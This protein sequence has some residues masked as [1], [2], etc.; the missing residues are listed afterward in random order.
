MSNDASVVTNGIAEVRRDHVWQW[1][2]G[3]HGTSGF[4][5][6]QGGS[7]TLLDTC[8]A[9]LILEGIGRLGDATHEQRESMGQFILA[10]QDRATGLFVDRDAVATSGIG[11]WQA[12][13]RGSWFALQALDALGMHP[14]H[15]FHF[16]D[17]IADR[18]GMIG[19]LKGLD[20][21]NAAAS[22]DL[23]AS[24]LQLLI[25][26]VEVERDPMAADLYHAV[27]D[28]LDASQD[29]NTGFWGLKPGLPLADGLRAI[30]RLLACYE[31]VQRPIMRVSMI[32]DAAMSLAQA[33]GSLIGAFGAGPR[34]EL[35]A[36]DIL[37]TLGGQFRY[38][39]DEIKQAL[40]ETRRV[41]G[42]RYR[43]HGG[44]HA[45]ATNAAAISEIES[46]WLRMLTIA[47]VEHA[48]PDPERVERPWCFRRWPTFGY[49]RNPG[50][51]NP[52]ERER[53]PLW[54]QRSAWLNRTPVATPMVSVVMPCYNLGRFLHLAVESVLA[55]T[56][57]DVEIVIVDDGSTD[58]FTIA[59]LDD[60]ERPR[61]RVLRQANGGVASARNHGIRESTG[62]Y[63]CCLDPDDQ[64]RPGFFERAVA[65]LDA[66]ADVGIVAGAI[67]MFDERNEVTRSGSQCDLPRLL[68][69]NAIHEAS[70]FRRSAWER[71]GGYFGSFST[72]G[73]EDWDLWLHLC[74][75]GFRI[76]VLPEVVVDYRIRVD[77]MSSEMYQPDRWRKLL[78][79]LADRHRESYAVHFG[80]VVGGLG[81]VIATQHGWI[82]NRRRS[83]AWWQRNG[84][85]WQR[86]A[87]ERRFQEMAPAFV[88]LDPKSVVPY[89]A[90]I[91]DPVATDFA[92]TPASPRR[93]PYGYA[94]A[95]PS[96]PPAVSIITPFFNIGDIFH[97]TASTVFRQSLQQWEWIIVNDGSTDPNALAMLAR[98]R[99]MDPRIRVLDHPSNF[100]LSA[101]RNTGYRAARSPYVVQLDGDDLLEPTAIEKWFWFLESHPE[102]DFAKGYTVG[103]GAQQY[104]WNKGFHHGDEFLNSNLVNPTTIVR[105]S[106]HEKVG[107]YDEADR[108]GLMDWNFWLRCAN[109]GHWGA[110]VPEYLDW[111]RRRPSHND[112]WPDFDEGERQSAY[113]EQLKHKFPGLWQ[114]GFPQITVQPRTT[115]DAAHD[116]LPCAN[117]LV[118]RK[119]RLLLLAPWL[120]C[121]GADRFNLDV[122]DQLTA[123]GWEATIAT[124]LNG[125]AGWASEYARYTPD[126]FLLANFL[127]KVDFPRF[128]RY[129]IGSRQ[130]DVVLVSHSELAYKLLPYLRAHCPGVTFV[131]YCHIDEPVWENGG[132]PRFSVNAHEGLDLSIVSSE[133]LKRWMVR[134]GAS[135]DR[136]RICY[137]NVDTET[138][139]PDPI[140]R[141][142]TR[143]EFGFPDSLPVILFVGRICQQKQ[144]R[145]LGE[146]LRSLRDAGG[147]FTALVAGGGPDFEQLRAFVSAN[148]LESHI[149]LIGEIPN[150]RVRDLMAAADIFFLPSQWEGISLAIYEAMACG[151]AI[152]GADVGGQRELV[153]P[154]CGVLIERGSEEEEAARYAQVLGDLLAAPEHR[155]ALGRNACARVRASF[156]LSAMGRQMDALLAEAR[157]LHVTEPRPSVSIE[158]GHAAAAL[159]AGVALSVA[160]APAKPVVALPVPLPYR[161][162]RRLFRPVYHWG[163]RHRWQWLERI[164]ARVRRSLV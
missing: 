20:W 142:A 53:M 12:S 26:R 30:H 106:L 124:T 119:P 104:L 9:V 134:E 52:G 138:W 22:A 160:N 98:Y 123:L 94:P 68:T 153:T 151:L 148:G 157:R 40:L 6:Y 32:I 145:V 64:L 109:A 126:I 42:E 118:E 101:A 83:L 31:Y 93:R 129:L 62:R 128:L 67:E 139:R 4:R 46:T 48:C 51:L 3:F 59:L 85:D 43:N 18:P 150:E 37:A 69:Q 36:V 57:E 159:A 66:Q 97:E 58:E 89:S 7:E 107:G 113:R 99:D 47:A 88:P 50:R 131:D 112:L 95:N 84:A 16:M 158:A 17:A 135:P 155:A 110:T 72:P 161:I 24:V 10:C 29:P 77:Q 61:T 121:G 60:F 76:E 103:F 144:P 136:V 65:V 74:E 122:L 8:C 105:R 33:D 27:L 86:I 23:V 78:C 125:D 146:S 114:G 156:K 13:V 87:E 49:H 79:E 92:N 140:R 120:T 28:E 73:I 35:A 91:V 115:F 81:A 154:E 71:S 14:E 130:I 39:R 127:E 143:A 54:L 11:D 111:Y 34:E 2:F 5:G 164:G 38:R 141:A 162:L 63:I 149:G 80:E 56:F 55:Q 82:D 147:K 1:L 45:V 116:V 19:W 75:M 137:T 102:F 108:G 21:S 152:V 41:L 117:R 44:F 132:H 70:V 100:G 25:Y 133:H 15:R 96:A 163:L 90:A